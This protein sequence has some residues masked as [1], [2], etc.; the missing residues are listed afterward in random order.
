LFCF[1]RPSFL[2]TLRARSQHNGLHSPS[3]IQVIYNGYLKKKQAGQCYAEFGKK[4][5]RKKR[6]K[7]A[8]KYE[9]SGD[10]DYNC[11]NTLDKFPAL[12]RH[13]FRYS[14]RL[15]SKEVDEQKKKKKKKRT[16]NLANASENVLRRHENTPKTS[17]IVARNE[18]CPGAAKFA[19]TTAQSEKKKK[20]KKKK[21]DASVE[22]KT[23]KKFF[24]SDM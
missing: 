4:K 13:R 9:K 17:H 18:P 6:K 3:K 12:Q 21:S 23:M 5:K 11:R 10:D 14:G 20:K 8:K 22:A 2:P 24:T 15:R 19:L 1:A 7:K 16:R